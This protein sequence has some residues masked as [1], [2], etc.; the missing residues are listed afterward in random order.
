[1]YLIFDHLTSIVMG[2]VVLLLVA[3]LHLGTQN[4]NIDAI[5]SETNRA[6]LLDFVHVLERDLRNAGSGA[7]EPGVISWSGAVP[8]AGQPVTALEFFTTVDT[9][10]TALPS[11]LRY[12]IAISDSSRIDG[13]WAYLYELRRLEYNGSAFALVSSSTPTVRH[14]A[15]TLLDDSGAVTA[16]PSLARAFAVRVVTIS[17]HG[18]DKIT[19]DSR[20]ET[21]IWPVN[22]RLF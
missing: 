18:A 14:F 5:R 11:R 7:T 13:Q 22:L 3:G 4:E 16:Q 8:S 21:V 20:W 17:P 15:L 10:A 1:M 2:T 12:D 9:S 6:R 19:S